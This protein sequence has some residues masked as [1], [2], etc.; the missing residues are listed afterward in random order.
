MVTGCIYKMDRQILQV[1]QGD[2]HRGGGEMVTDRPLVLRL[3]K[4]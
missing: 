1:L 3:E 4:A 2:S